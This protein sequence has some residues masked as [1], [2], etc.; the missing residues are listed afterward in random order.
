MTVREKR[1]TEANHR[2]KKNRWKREI[3]RENGRI[4]KLNPRGKS[5]FLKFGLER[6]IVIF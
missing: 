3:V 4:L 1:D 2:R 5:D 6:K